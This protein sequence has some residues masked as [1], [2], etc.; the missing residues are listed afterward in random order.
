MEVDF[1][2]QHTTPAPAHAG[3][4]ATIA[5]PLEG[6]FSLDDFLATHPA[7]HDAHTAAHDAHTAAHEAANAP[8]GKKSITVSNLSP[9]QPIAVGARSSRDTILLHEKCQALAIPQPVFTIGPS[10]ATRWTVEVNFPGLVNA[11]E[12]QSLKENGCFSSK[13]EAKEAASKTALAIL[14]E[15]EQAGRITNPGRAKKPKGEPGYQQPIEREEPG[16]N[17]VGQLLEFQ[18]SISAP[19][20]TYT[21]YQIGIRWACLM[22]IEGHPAPFSSLDSQFNSKKA[23]RQH[24]A[25]CAVTYFKA[26]GLWPSTYTDG[27]GI[28]KR[29]SAPSHTDPSSPSTPQPST[30]PSPSGSSSATQQVAALAATLNLGTPEWRFSHAD[31]AAP[32]LHTVGCYFRDGGAHEGPLGEVRNVFGKKR[33]KEECA[34]LTLEYLTRLRE[35]REEMARSMMAGFGGLTGVPRAAVGE[36]VGGQG[37]VGSEDEEVDVFEDAMD[38]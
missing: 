19:Q 3:G 14:E 28:K 30:T 31:P 5:A 22:E 35:D 12:L 8:L 13:Q 16:E 23:A 10:G 11:E 17:Y 27:G 18:R 2:T 20:P 25:G 1:L 37:D 36:G 24:A 21:D 7:A 4:D 15:L 33:A 6:V 29:K 32:E 34:R 26:Q 9:F 38:Q